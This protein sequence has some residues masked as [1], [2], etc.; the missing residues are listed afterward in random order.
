M[1]DKEVVVF[2]EQIS[3]F[4]FVDFF[5][6]GACEYMQVLTK[7]AC[8]SMITLEKILPYLFSV[9]Y[10]YRFSVVFYLFYFYH[11]ITFFIYWI[12]P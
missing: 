1:C 4:F 3:H 7:K 5:F 8:V 6:F 11:F 9:N 2:C 10:S 12:I